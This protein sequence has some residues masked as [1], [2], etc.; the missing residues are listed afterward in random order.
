MNTLENKQVNEEVEVLNYGFTTSETINKT[1]YAGASVS[2]IGELNIDSLYNNFE[3]EYTSRVSNMDLNNIDEL[4]V[5]NEI[6]ICY[7]PYIQVYYATYQSF[8]ELNKKNNNMYADLEAQAIKHFIDV[9]NISMNK[10]KS[11][12]KTR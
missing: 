3:T 12:G 4:E 1:L 6:S 5:M 2:N 9:Y 11:N 8:R 7:Y 10:M